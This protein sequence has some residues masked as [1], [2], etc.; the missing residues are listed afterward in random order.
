SGDARAQLALGKALLLGTGGVARDYPRA[1]HLLRQA[2]DRGDAA[3]AY[4]LGLMYRSGYGTAANTA[5]AAHWFDGAARHGIPAAMFMLANAYRDGDGV[6]RDEARALALY[7]QAAE[8]E[9]PEAVQALAMAYQN[10]EL[11][12]ARDDAA[13]RK[14]WLETAHALKHPALAP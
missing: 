5:L 4:Y 7:E 8:H 3:A 14:Q 12:L 6:P 11:G 2:A 9:L 10:G 13:F 1:L